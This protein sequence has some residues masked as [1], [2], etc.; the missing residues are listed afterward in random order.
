MKHC[1]W[2]MYYI[3]FTGSLFAF[4]FKIRAARNFRPCFVLSPDNLCRTQSSLS[5]AGLEM[6]LQ[7][8]MAWLGG[9]FNRQ[10]MVCS[11]RPSFRITETI[12]KSGNT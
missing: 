8:S 6:N 1:S 12:E 9:F 10:E 7:N 4:A 5:A 2:I 11:Y 3:V